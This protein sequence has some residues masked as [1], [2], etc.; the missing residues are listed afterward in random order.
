MTAREPMTTWD[1]ARI[2]AAFRARFDVA[3]AP[4]LATRILLELAPAPARRML[5]FRR[6][7]IVLV[8]AAALILLLIGSQAGL[9]PTPR[10]TTRPTLG[11]APSG[12][13]DTGVWFPTSAQVGDR[14]YEVT[15]VIDALALRDRGDSTTIAVAGWYRAGKPVP[16]ALQ[17]DEYQP[18]EGCYW[19]T[20]WLVDDPSHLTGV[21]GPDDSIGLHPVTDWHAAGAADPAPVVFVGHF[22]DPAAA[23]CPAGDRR[24]VCADRFVV[25]AVA[26]DGSVRVS[27]VPTEAAGL[28]V[29][30]VAT[31][32]D[33]RAT[34]GPQELAVFGWLDDL[35]SG[36]CALL[37]GP[38]VP[39]LWGD[40]NSHIPL[41][42][43]P[44]SL[45]YA[46]GT[47][48]TR[49][50]PTG[51]SIDTALGFEVHLRTDV[52]FPPG[53]PA[54]GP[55]VPMPVVLLGHFDDRRATYCGPANQQAC[56]DRFVIDGET[57]AAD[58]PWHLGA[59]GEWETNVQIPASILDAVPSTDQILQVEHGSEGLL[60][61]EEPPAEVAGLQ[62]STS[63]WLVIALPTPAAGASIET[64]LIDDAGR[65]YLAT[66]GSDKG[67]VLQSGPAASP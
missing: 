37:E 64:W 19:N 17:P 44:E 18:L 21:A 48:R 65:V 53:G 49:H 63:W 1:D 46:D 66:N 20:S 27:T 25:T 11:P 42:Q 5:A 6:S 56:R 67:F 33:Q 36:T 3:P 52:R 4:T 57:W 32:L 30:D 23:N 34:V 62:L 10:A 29:V 50:A 40:C 28:P 58:T 39:P 41:M 7:A 26:W 8:A 14:T 55:S 61:L 24:Q 51:P 38:V 43:H 9:I 15:G 31:A 60:P 35:P 59:R 2:A 54:F 16:C 12:S 13:T 47:K 45:T 22:N